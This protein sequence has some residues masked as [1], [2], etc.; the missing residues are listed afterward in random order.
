VTR[1]ELIALIGPNG[2]G[3]STLIDVIAGRLPRYQGSCFLR[4]VDIRTMNRPQLCRQV[5]HVPQQR[6]DNVH[7]TVE[8]VI[9]TGRTPHSS[10]FY[11]TDE[12]LSALET[13]LKLTRL[14]PFRKRQFSR[15]SGGEQQRVL[16]AAAIA[17]AAPVLLLD[18][19]GAHLDPENQTALWDLLA[20]LRDHGR[21]IVI[22]THHLHLAARRSDRV[23]VLSHGRLV[24]DAAPTHAMRPE[25]LEAVFHVPFEWHT[26]EQGR[27]FLNYG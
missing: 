20:L 10:G 22:V 14:E 3:K 13:A 4:G 27:V 8:E 25:Q 15:L 2:A 6:I 26:N 21:L 1:P 24:A 5:A 9:L 18:E 11:E 7:F 16:V 23:W 17:Q 19:P 12:D